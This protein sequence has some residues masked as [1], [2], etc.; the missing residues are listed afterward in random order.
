MNQTTAVPSSGIP[1][2]I[3]T[4]EQPEQESDG[5]PVYRKRNGTGTTG[6][7]AKDF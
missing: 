7:D 4:P 2:S 6:T 3:D 1:V 5:I